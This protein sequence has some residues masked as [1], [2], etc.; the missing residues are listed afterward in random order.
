MMDLK[1]NTMKIHE[2]GEHISKFLDENGLS[3]ENSLV[4]SVSKNE[5]RKI[6]EDLYYRKVEKLELNY[7][8]EKFIIRKPAFYYDEINEQLC[9]D[10]FIIDEDCELRYSFNGSNMILTVK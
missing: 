5:I 6:D 4:I 2:L 7:F 8:G 1:L 3:K 9:I 10:D